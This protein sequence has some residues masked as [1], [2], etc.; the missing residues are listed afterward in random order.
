MV[1]DVNPKVLSASMLSGDSVKNRQGE[2]LGSIKDFMI[3][4]NTG[5]VAY[6]V[7]SFGGFRGIG[8][9]L[10]AVPWHALSLDTENRYFILDV[11]KELLRDAPGFDKDE[12]PD[13]A[14]ETWGRGIHDF[15]GVRPYWESSRKY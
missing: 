7:L 14:D 15:Y 9:K 11:D 8:D 4:L 2:D 10:F 13:M 3:D 1:S 5:C 12:W 6:A